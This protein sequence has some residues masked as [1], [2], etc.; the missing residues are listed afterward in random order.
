MEE[1]GEERIKKIAEDWFLR[2]PLLFSVLC[3]HKTVTNDSLHIPFRTGK[4]RIEFSE[5]LL[6][7]L[8][9]RDLEEYLRI[10]IF[11]IL[12]KHPYQ[13]Q[14]LFAIPA[15]LTYA[16]NYTINDVYKFSVS[17]DG[18]GLFHLPRN[19]CFEEYYAMIAD[20][21]DN[22][23]ET[24]SS[25]KNNTQNNSDGKGK[26]ASGQVNG[27]DS[28]NKGKSEQES[29][30][31]SIGE[32][33]SDTSSQATEASELWEEDSEIK[34][35]INEAIEIAE[36]SDGWGSITGSL[37]D[38]I[39]ASKYIAVDYRRILSFYRT[40]ILSSK[41]HLT[42]MRPSRRYGFAAM[43]SRYDLKSNLLVAVDVSGSISNVSLA[44][45]YSIINYFFKYGIEKIDVIQFDTEIKGN[46]VSLKKVRKNVEVIG[47]G[48]TDFAA[49]INYY[50]EHQKEYDGLIIFTD[51]DAP[52]QVLKS[53]IYE[54]LWV[55]QSYESYK[56]FFKEMQDIKT[57]GKNRIT[58]IPL[59][60]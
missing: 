13:R 35:K 14:P 29:S 49:P 36:S 53:C 45:F 30:S 34:T 6:K 20:L 51:G 4:Q 48:G 26:N 46:A 43:G 57:H 56:D 55:L 50:T 18:L 15:V 60:K 11:R 9:D 47:R 39:T 54:I 2:E 58:Y 1:T 44:K 3:T 7:K 41:R 40:S 59:P 19:L 28:K 27:T 31:G 25:N 8:S 32:S 38:K 23:S 17:L 24:D 22:Q 52:L 33:Q 16:S 5:P 37:R 21:L 42:R 12:L 10:E